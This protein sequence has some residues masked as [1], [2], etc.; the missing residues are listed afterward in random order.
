MYGRKCK[1]I[2]NI[3]LNESIIYA[4]VIIP[5]SIKDEI[6]KMDGIMLKGNNVVIEEIRKATKLCK[7]YLQGN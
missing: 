3:E 1:F 6:I 4:E 2:H 7:F 5:E